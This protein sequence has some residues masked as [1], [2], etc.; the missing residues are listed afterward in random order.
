MK[1][2]EEIKI[3]VVLRQEEDV[4]RTSANDNVGTLPDFPEDFWFN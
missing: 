2:Y 4:I 3:V 1:S